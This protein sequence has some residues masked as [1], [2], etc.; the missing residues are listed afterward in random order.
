MCC[1]VYSFG[2]MYSIKLTHCKRGS[3]VIHAIQA[4][5]DSQNSKNTNLM[6]LK[7]TSFV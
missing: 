6:Y 3:W 1:L 2:Y 4:C 5:M 7:V